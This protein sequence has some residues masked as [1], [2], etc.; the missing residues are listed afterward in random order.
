MEKGTRTRKLGRADGRE[1]GARA[2]ETDG[3]SQDHSVKKHDTRK[4]TL[5]RETVRILAGGEL[6]KVAGG[7]ANVVGIVSG[8][9]QDCTYPSG[10]FPCPRVLE[11]RSPTLQPV[12]YNPLNPERPVAY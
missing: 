9:D 8:D 11:G 7:L 6:G 4:L 2:Q 10:G 5:A 12:L 1:A 3:P